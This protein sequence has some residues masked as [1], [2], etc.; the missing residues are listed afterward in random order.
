MI[1]KAPPGLLRR[2]TP[3]RALGLALLA[4]GLLAI[5]ENRTEADES[6]WIGAVLAAS[7][8]VGLFGRDTIGRRRW[9][10]TLAVLVLVLA[11]AELAVRRE[12]A[13]AQQDFAD[14]QMRF[15]EDAELKYEFKPGIAC[16][17]AKLN[18][19]GMLDV[20]RVL[21]KPEGTLRVACLGDSVGG[22]CQLARTNACAALEEELSKALGGRKVESLNFSV[23]GYNT[24]QEARALEAKAMAFQPDAIVVLYVLNDPFPDLAMVQH[25]PGHF[26]FEHLLYFGSMT[27]LGR[28]FPS[29]DP[30]ISGLVKLHDLERAWKGVVVEGFS[31]IQAQAAPRSLPVVVAIFPLFIEPPPPPLAAVYEKVAAEG[32]RHG[33]TS[34]DL[35]REVYAGE[36]LTAF[37]KPSRDIIHPTARAHRLAAQA[38]A[39]A[40]VDARPAWKTTP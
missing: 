32:R 40:L 16:G 7:G 1:P 39:R 4:V 27:A 17:E 33:F 22:D 6:L 34:I 11:G 24:M 30:T 23:P 28:R 5:G 36:P 37:L 9:V 38:I 26:K 25:L 15:V 20:P 18:D 3:A 2:F 35:V 14:R 8:V 19:L 29:L 12:S 31:R 21:E 10:E 13:L